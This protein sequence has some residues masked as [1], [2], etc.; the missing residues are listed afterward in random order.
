[1]GMRYIFICKDESHRWIA[2]QVAY[3]ELKSH[4]RRDW[5]GR[6]HLEYRYRRV[7]GQENRSEGERLSVNYLEMEIWNEELREEDVGQTADCGRGRWKIENEYNHVLKNRGYN[8][9]HNF[10]QGK[11]HASEVFCLLNVLSYLIHG[12]QE[13]ADEEYRKAGGL[14]GAGCI[15]LGVAV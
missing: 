7:N 1:M 2:E 9:K 5:N 10:G 12:I 8:L 3:G 14:W 13:L 15:F 11:G 4:R 6:N